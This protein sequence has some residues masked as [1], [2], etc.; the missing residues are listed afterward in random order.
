MNAGKPEQ[1][2]AAP[3]TMA[4]AT[5]QFLLL[6]RIGYFGLLLLIPAWFL[7]LAPPS[8]GNPYLL[9][10]MLWLPLWFPLPGI[11]KADP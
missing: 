6:G 1:L 2:A 5:K 3:V 8:L 10:V 4:N 11:I 7:W 9:T